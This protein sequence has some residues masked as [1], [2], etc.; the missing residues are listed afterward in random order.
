MNVQELNPIG[1][2]AANGYAPAQPG[3]LFDPST[4]FPASPVGDR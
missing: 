1:T 2:G 4:P 3:F